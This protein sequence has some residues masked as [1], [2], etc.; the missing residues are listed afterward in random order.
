M[1]EKQ[2]LEEI[3]V[4]SRILIVFI[5]SILG[6]AAIVYS[7]T[8]KNHLLSSNVSLEKLTVAYSDKDKIVW[9][10]EDK[11]NIVTEKVCIRDSFM[12]DLPEVGSVLELYVIRRITIRQSFFGQSYG[13]RET[14]VLH[15]AVCQ[16]F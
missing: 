11:T 8:D 3:T 9:L 15:S 2:N 7:L 13:S 4:I 12:N 5:I 6:I 14:E 10:K 16:K 1:G